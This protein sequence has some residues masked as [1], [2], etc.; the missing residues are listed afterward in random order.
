MLRDGEPC[1]HVGCL[2]HRTH[3]CEG[4]GRIEGK[5]P[6]LT[7]ELVKKVA[8]KHYEEGGDTIIECWSDAE[9]QDWIDGTGEWAETPLNGAKGTMKDLLCM[10]DLV[11]SV[12]EDIQNS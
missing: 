10:F 6:E 3:P 7:V 2:S 9:I 8:M 1:K 12:R 5:Y 4:C 11:D